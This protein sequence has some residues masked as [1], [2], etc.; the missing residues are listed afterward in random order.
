MV[1]RLIFFL[2]PIALLLWR[3]PAGPPTGPDTDISK[4]LS[5]NCLISPY[6]DTLKVFV[7]K[8]SEISEYE[9]Y[10][11]SY[12][13]FY[14]YWSVSGVKVIVAVDGNTLM[15]EEDTLK[16]YDEFYQIY[17]YYY[18]RFPNVEVRPGQRWELSVSHPDFDSISAEAIVP[19]SVILTTLPVDTITESSEKLLF[20][21][22]QANGAGGYLPL[23]LFTAEKNS[24]EHW[25]QEIYLS[26]E[27]NHIDGHMEG[28]GTT[29]NPQKSLSVQYE[30]TTL[31]EEL[32][33][34][35]NLD[36]PELDSLHQYESLYLQFFLYSLNEA[37]YNIQ[38]LEIKPDELSGFNAPVR[39]FSNVENGSGILGAFW[40]TASK[41]IIIDKE[42]LIGQ[43]Q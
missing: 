42:F 6:E 38:R 41:K 34:F 8:W 19:D 17:H 2:F 25:L 16:K 12:L 29:P 36:H 43:C 4:N 35:C 18:Y 20:A 30:M 3:C 39:V 22:T 24:G 27:T 28:G 1:R 23:L 15:V 40:R 10:V 9:N 37:L 31:I 14:D 7:S 11:A 26:W 5:V 21:W 33:Y 32:K 13:T